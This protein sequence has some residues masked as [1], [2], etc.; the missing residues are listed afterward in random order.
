LRPRPLL[1]GSDI[2]GSDIIGSDIIGF[3]VRDARRYR[4]TGLLA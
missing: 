1:V 4:R 3:T 2:I